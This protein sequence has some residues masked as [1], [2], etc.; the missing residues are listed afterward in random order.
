MW[1]LVSARAPIPVGLKTPL[2]ATGS[3]RM[4][5][6][7]LFECSNEKLTNLFYS[8]KVSTP[9]TVNVLNPT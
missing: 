5:R 4:M 3:R 7:R 1:D 9:L 6:H 8:Q 2:W